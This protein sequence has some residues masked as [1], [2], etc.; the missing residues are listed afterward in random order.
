MANIDIN[1]IAGELDTFIRAGQANFKLGSGLA[2][3]VQAGHQPQEPKAGRGVN[4]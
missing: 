4:A 2:K 3:F 1:I